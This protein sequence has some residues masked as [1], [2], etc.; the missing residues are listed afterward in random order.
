MSEILSQK[1]IDMLLAEL[2]SGTIDPD[3]IGTESEEQKVKLYNFRH[4]KKLAR[5]QLRTLNMIYENY[6]RYVSTTLAAQ[7]RA[8]T[9]LKVASVEPLTYEEFIRSLP[10]STVI[11]IGEMP[12]LK[13]KFLIEINPNIAFVIIERLFG[14]SGMV[15]NESRPFTDIEE[16]AFR[17]VLEWFFQEIPEAWNNVISDLEPKLTEIES[18]PMFTQ[19]VH[20]NDMII[21]V[22]FEAKINEVEGFI[23]FCLPYLMLEPLVGRL[24]AQH[25]FSGTQEKSVEYEDQIKDRL[26]HSQV[27]L[28]AELAATTITYRDLTLLQPGDVFL[29]ETS[30]NRPLE[31]K[32]GTRTKFLGAAG[33]IGD[34]LA[35]KITSTGIEREVEEDVW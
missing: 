12:P 17:R 33:R 16:M 14:G 35:V 9:S 4:P 25:W 24:T 15:Q 30:I 29:L 11:G 6:A 8:F 32:V 13:G 34:R 18:N 3:D 7:L 31:I 5:D 22:T 26:A 28:S 2:N 19:I 23:N 27:M 10:T 20:H 1:E 21:L